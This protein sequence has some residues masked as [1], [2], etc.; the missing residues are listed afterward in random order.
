MI[1]YTDNKT[2]LKPF[3]SKTNAGKWWQDTWILAQN[4]DI[5]L[6]LKFV[7]GVDNPADVLTR[8]EN[9]PKYTKEQKAEF[10]RQ[11]WLKKTIKQDTK[12]RIFQEKSIVVK[13][14]KN[15]QVTEQ[16]LIKGN[17][18]IC[19]SKNYL[20]SSLKRHQKKLHPEM[21]KL[22]VDFGNLMKTIDQDDLKK[23]TAF[24]KNLL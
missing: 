3:V 19:K 14:R 5:N 8:D 15:N 16:N 17:C 13:E 6:T 23:L 21:K 2:L 20:Q 7:C 18:F 24:V 1:I 9:K 10:F 11:Q 12:K 4:N 22:K